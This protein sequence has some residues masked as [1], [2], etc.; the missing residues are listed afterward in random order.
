MASEKVGLIC[1][2]CRKL[3]NFKCFREFFQ[4]IC[5]K[6][7]KNCFYLKKKNKI[8]FNDLEIDDFVK[9]R[10]EKLNQGRENQNTSNNT[11]KK[12][13][14]EKLDLKLVRDL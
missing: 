13:P 2:S 8:E 6:L 7:T 11:R 9:K 4:W 10:S 14:E 1:A 5:R 12:N 3:N